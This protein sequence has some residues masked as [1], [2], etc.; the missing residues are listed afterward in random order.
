MVWD[1]RYFM[2]AN[3]SVAETNT[4]K[5]VFDA[6]SEI[7]RKKESQYEENIIQVCVEEF[8]LNKEEVLTN[9]KKVIDNKCLNNVFLKISLMKYLIG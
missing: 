8:H 4:W 7:K 9:L 3:G 1:A 6:I 2:M 5:N